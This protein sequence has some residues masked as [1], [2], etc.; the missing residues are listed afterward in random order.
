MS[1]SYQNKVE[2]FSGRLETAMKGQSVRS[3]ARDANVSETVIRKYLSGE[4]TPNLE[5]LAAIASAA[6]VR[7]EWLAT[8]EEPKKTCTASTIS[9]ELSGEFFKYWH[10]EMG[11]FDIRLEQAAIMFATNYSRLPEEEKIDGLPKVEACDVLAA[12][13]GDPLTIDL[14]QISDSQ[15]K[16][17]IDAQADAINAH[18][19]LILMKDQEIA[20]LQ[21]ELERLTNTPLGVVEE[22]EKKQA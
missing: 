19:E 18:K 8:G 21:M 20:R 17:T 12:Y 15:A 6:N 1:S 14:G 3:F 5:R 4:T 16:Q 11:D 9:A 22:S 2:H 10:N 13:K 7:M